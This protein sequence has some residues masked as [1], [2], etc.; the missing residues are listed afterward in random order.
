MVEEADVVCSPGQRELAARTAVLVQ[1]MYEM[2]G[3]TWGAD[4]GDNPTAHVPDAESIAQTIEAL[5]KACVV[6]G[7]KSASTGRLLVATD[8]DRQGVFL[9]LGDYDEVDGTVDV[10]DKLKLR[11]V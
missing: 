1:R 5:M 8:N 3:W 2:H 11:S 4:W 10:D 9:W 7:E 6:N